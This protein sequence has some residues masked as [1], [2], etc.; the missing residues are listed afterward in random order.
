MNFN[1][2]K[3]LCTSK[4]R[5]FVRSWIGVERMPPT[6]EGEKHPLRAD[7]EI[8]CESLL[9]QLTT[10]TQPLTFPLLSIAT[11]TGFWT[12][13]PTRCWPAGSETVAEAV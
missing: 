1:V 11:P 7:L 10:M 8:A 13:N 4:R 5:I 2:S 3:M 9:V 6:Y 12:Q